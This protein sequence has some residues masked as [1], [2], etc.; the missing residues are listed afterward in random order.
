MEQLGV[1]VGDRVHVT[2]SAIAGPTRTFTVVG[3]TVAPWIDQTQSFTGGGAIV[4]HAGLQ[5]LIP[6]DT[7]AIPTPSD[8]FVDFAP[9]PAQ[10]LAQRVGDL[11][12]QLGQEYQVTGA[13]PPTDLLNFGRVQSLPLVLA[14]L[15][16]G[17]AAVTL[18]LTLVAGITRRRDEMAILKAVG[19]R[20]RQLLGIVAWES[21]VMTL[22][23]VGI[24]VPLGVALGRWLWTAV[25]D[26][27]GLMADPVVPLGQL[28]LAA[29]AA[30]ILANLAATWPGL[31]AARTPVATVL[32]TS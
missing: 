22:V 1:S 19:Y 18:F 21:M 7:R 27:M 16:V 29:V 3:T 9:A 23:G 17:L 14:L 10:E 15:L 32:R 12:R 26:H 20:P 13:Q 8:A 5:R 25:V 6:A 28:V 24:G 11:Q 30:V 4:T 31:L 2:I